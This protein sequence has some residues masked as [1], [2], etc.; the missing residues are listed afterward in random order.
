M[1]DTVDRE[2]FVV[3]SFLLLAPATKIKNSIVHTNVNGKGRQPQK[4]EFF[5]K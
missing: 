3:K 4:S 1:K 2:I 5:Q